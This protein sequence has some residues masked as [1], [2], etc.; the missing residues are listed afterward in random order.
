MEYSNLSELSKRTGIAQEQLQYCL[1]HEMIPDWLVSDETPEG[2]LD[3]VAA[4]LVAGAAF[5]LQA[6]CWPETVK[7]F[8]HA[9]SRV[10][11]IRERRRPLFPFVVE[12]IRG[13]QRSMIQMADSSHVR[14]KVGTT[15]SGWVAIG[16]KTHERDLDFEPRAMIALDIAMVR[17]LVRG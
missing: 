5:L 8:L 12:A 9:A 7:R 2:Q 11:P 17:D 4:I 13:K 10:Y 3:Y 16:G 1:D 15:D 14:C 6:G